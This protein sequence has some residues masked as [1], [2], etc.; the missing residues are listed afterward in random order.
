MRVGRADA[1][2]PLLFGKRLDEQEAGEANLFPGGAIEEMLKFFSSS[3][4]CGAS[5]SE[6]KVGRD[7]L[8]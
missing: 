7:G 4:K 1:F 2:P 5:L 8:L 3:R 6:Q